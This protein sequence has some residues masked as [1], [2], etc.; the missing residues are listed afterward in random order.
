[1]NN[2]LR[3]AIVLFI[4]LSALTGLAYPLAVTGLAQLAFPQAAN[5]SLVVRGGHVVGSELIGQAFADPGGI[6]RLRRRPRGPRR[7][8]EAP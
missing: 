8:P 7:Q 2:S 6:V 5:G 4:V 1:M 3:S